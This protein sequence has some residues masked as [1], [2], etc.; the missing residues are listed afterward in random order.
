MKTA[1]LS[2]TLLIF[3]SVFS[4]HAAKLGLASAWLFEEGG[5]DVVKGCCQC[6]HDGEIKGSLKWVDDGKFGRCVGNFLV[7]CRQSRPR[8][9]MMMFSTQTLILFR[10]LDQIKCCFMAI[11]RLAKWR[12]LART[13]RTCTAS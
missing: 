3:L 2:L 11:C 1:V 6:E 10:R 5:G 4:A 9:T 8:S 7:R 12:C 13:P